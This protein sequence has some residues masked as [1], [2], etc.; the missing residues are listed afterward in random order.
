MKTIAELRRICQTVH[1]EDFSAQ[2][3]RRVS[4]YITLVLIPTRISAN[5]VSLV[6]LLLGILC[7][8]F[9]AFQGSRALLIGLILFT[10]NTILDGVDGELARYHRQSSLTGLFLDRINSIFVYP[11]LFGGLTV[12]VIREHCILWGLTFGLLAT[13]GSIG[14]RAIKTSIDASALDGLTLEKARQEEKVE[15]PTGLSTAPLSEVLRSRSNWYMKLID[16]VTVRQPG[17]NIILI[18]AIGAKLFLRYLERP[19]PLFLDPIILI[20]IFY[21][22]FFPTAAVYGLFL[23]IHSR[24]VEQRFAHVRPNMRGGNV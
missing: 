15:P 22:I 24:Q 14:I 16:F 23:I 13:W 18:L 11:A 10:A 3:V 19:L 17:I 12:G 4:I 6:N 20:L 9:F 8:V 2:I 21:G 5:A 1:S 7:G